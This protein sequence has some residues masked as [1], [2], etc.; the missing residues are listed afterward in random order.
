V[1][2]NGDRNG[3]GNFGEVGEVENQT[4]TYERKKVT[5]V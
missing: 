4:P 1:E 2:R 3:L 5:I